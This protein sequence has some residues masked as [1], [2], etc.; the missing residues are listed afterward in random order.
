MLRAYRQKARPDPDAE[1]DPDAGPRCRAVCGGD[2]GDAAAGD[3]G[4][5]GVDWKFAVL[6]EY[7]GNGPRCRK[8]QVIHKN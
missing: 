5:G 6:L 7:G 1:T 4:G 8:C 3:L 2:A